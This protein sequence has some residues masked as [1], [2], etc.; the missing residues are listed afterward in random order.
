M[1]KDHLK[2]AP[3]LIVYLRII[4]VLDLLKPALFEMKYKKSFYIIFDEFMSVV[5]SQK[6]PNNHFYIFLTKWIGFLLHYTKYNPESAFPLLSKYFFLL[7][8]QLQSH[9]QLIN[10]R[11][12]V[13]QLKTQWK[14]NKNK[15]EE[16]QPSSTNETFSFPST[17][18]L[19]NL[20]PIKPTEAL[21]FSFPDDRLSSF[22]S[23]FTEKT[24]SHRI[25]MAIAD[26]DKASQKVPP[27]LN[28]F[29][30]NIISLISLENED[31]RNYAYALALRYVKH[32]PKDANCITEAFVKSLPNLSVAH[33][34]RAHRFAADLL[35][36]SPEYSEHLLQYV[37]ALSFED[38]NAGAELLNLLQIYKI[39]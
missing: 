35:V 6:S 16:D 24:S 25:L 29:K 39:L 38:K 23:A 34:I 10:L 13:S 21:P 1:S 4:N 22:R 36:Y 31:I 30:D 19:L 20:L 2:E 26:L 5:A 33:Q 27:L 18:F 37:F 32:Y 3:S 9:P 11:L 17:D 8:Q 28:V 15:T 12:L 14:K 7:R